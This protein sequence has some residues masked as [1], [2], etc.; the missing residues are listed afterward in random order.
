MRTMPATIISAAA[1][2]RSQ[3]MAHLLL[4]VKSRPS[5]RSIPARIPCRRGAIVSARQSVVRNPRNPGGAAPAPGAGTSGQRSTC[6]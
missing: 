6:G 3:D 4:C 1:A 5:R 2:G